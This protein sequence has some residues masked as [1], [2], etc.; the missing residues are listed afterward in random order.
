MRNKLLLV[1]AA[2]LIAGF[3]IWGSY[4]SAGGVEI[5]SVDLDHIAQLHPAFEEAQA[6]LMEEIEKMQ[7]ELEEMDQEEAMMMQ[8]QMDMEIEQMAMQLQQ[9]ALSEVQG[10]IQEFADAEN[11]Q[12]IVADGML[13]AGEPQKDITPEVLEYMG[14]EQEPIEE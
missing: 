14:L 4:S 13:L 3:G 5:V 7:A 9:E 1:A 6:Q 11:Y 10:E 8:Q 2:L 12:Y